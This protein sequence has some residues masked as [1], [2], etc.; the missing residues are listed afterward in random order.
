MYYF[1]VGFG[2]WL[3]VFFWGAGLAM[4]SMP[5][6]WA[7]FWPVLACPAGLALQSLVVWLGAYAGFAGTDVYAWWAEALPLVL[8]VAGGRRRGGRAARE[9]GRFA[10]LW[11]LMAANLAVLLTPLARAARGLNTLSLGS[12]DAADYAAGAR[13][14]KEFA[15][16]DRAGF[17]GLTEVVRVGSVDNFFD[18]WLRLNHFTPSALI[19]L[20]GTVL[21]CA[22]H[23]LTSVLTIV[24]LVCSLPVVFW[25]ARTLLGYPA[26]AAAW[27][28]GR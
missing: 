21:D 19:A 18:F 6:P 28:A 20:N 27:V 25:C 14:L 12:F 3:H 17:L 16:A 4:W 26:L 10:G 13:V 2:A 5:R 23:E 9:I 11:L 15:H 8:L 1:A 22:P 7:R 24:V